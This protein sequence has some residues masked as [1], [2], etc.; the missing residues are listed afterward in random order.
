[1]H[2]DLTLVYIRLACTHF[3]LVLRYPCKYPEGLMCR[4][5]EEGTRVAPDGGAC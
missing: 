3:G 1:M 4:Y 2:V 5:P